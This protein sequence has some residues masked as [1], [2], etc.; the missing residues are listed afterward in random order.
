MSDFDTVLAAN[1]SSLRIVV[2]GYIVR[3]PIGGMAWHHLQYVMGLA[4]MGHEVLFLEDSG[5]DPWACYDPRT[6]ETGIDPDYGL[7]FIRQV[8]ERVGLGGRWAYNDMFAGGWRGPAAHLVAGFCHDAVLLLNLSG[9]NPLRGF[10]A[11]VPTRVYLDTDPLFTQIRN[12]QDMD[13]WRLVAE[14]NAFFS[15]GENLR[16]DDCTI[17]D[18]GFPWQPTRQPV[19]LQ[20]WPTSPAPTMG[21]FT[22]VM[23]WDS[24]ANREY[25]GQ[26]YGMKSESFGPYLDLPRQVRVKLEIA[27]G[28]AD[29]PREQLRAKGWLLQ[30]P[31]E[32]TRDPWTY[33]AYIQCARG[34]FSV[35]KHGYVVSN[36]GWFSERSACY[37]ASGRPVVVEDTGFSARLP[38]GEGLLPFSNP[39]QAIEALEAANADYRKHSE[40][41][42]VIAEEYFE[43]GRVLEHLVERALE[44]PMLSEKPSPDR[45]RLWLNDYE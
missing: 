39:Q 25:G 18:D 7:K 35:A 10:L 14:H 17:P 21:A 24:Y 1:P 16:T 23:Q 45:D 40:A 20:S 41:A 2:L 42:R 28:S 32:V 13:R 9:A 33:Q 5:D 11:E 38:K 4:R 12:L 8:F 15:F 26:N 44:Q 19:D 31:I 6:G 34:E 22:T 30:N 36:S 29:A 27:L 3:C 43:A 37:L